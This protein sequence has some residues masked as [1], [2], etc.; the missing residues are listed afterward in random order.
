MTM[1]DCIQ[2]CTE[3][4]RTALEM[5]GYCTEQGGRFAVAERIRA[6]LDC[7]DSCEVAAKFML[8]G[9]ELHSAACSACAEVCDSCAEV[10]ERIDGDERV[11]RFVEKCRSTADLCD[12]M[13]DEPTLRVA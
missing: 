9:S 5:L 8:R 7:S 4:H 10:F 12:A 6:L 1:N 3:T 2:S 11:R 13:A